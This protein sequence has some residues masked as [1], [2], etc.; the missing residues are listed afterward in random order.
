MFELSVIGGRGRGREGRAYV[1]GCSCDWEV[2]GGVQS[3]PNTS[4]IVDIVCVLSNASGSSPSS[5]IGV[6]PAPGPD[7]PAPAPA[8]DPA[9]ISGVPV[10]CLLSRSEGSRLCALSRLVGRR[11]SVDRRRSESRWRRGG[12]DEWEGPGRDDSAL[13]GREWDEPMTCTAWPLRRQYP[14]LSLPSSDGPVESDDECPLST[15][16]AEVRRC[17][18]S[19]VAS[20]E[21]HLG[22]P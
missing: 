15:R 10:L 14:E 20:D 3:S 12:A 18:L 4:L 17:L 22:E 11:P 5:S 9:P 2:G 1:G 16:P 13:R 19:L 7:A 21:G 6:D 8:P